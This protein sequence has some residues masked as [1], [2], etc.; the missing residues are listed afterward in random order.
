MLS[1]VS[2]GVWLG[3]TVKSRGQEHKVQKEKASKVAGASGT[4]VSKPRVC[5][6]SF[7]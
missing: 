1:W 6:A 5:G 2:S 4:D 7:S 3:V